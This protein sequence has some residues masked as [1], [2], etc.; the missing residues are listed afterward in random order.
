[1]GHSNE[2]LAASEAELNASDA[3]RD[4]DHIIAIRFVSPVQLPEEATST[5]EAA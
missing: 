2:E 1:M 3:W 5:W 4:G